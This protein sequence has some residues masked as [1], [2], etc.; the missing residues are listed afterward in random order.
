M[1]RDAVICATIGFLMFAAFIGYQVFAIGA[2]PLTL[3]VGLV[4]LMC[5][6]DFVSTIRED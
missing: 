4:L 5:L 1:N 2:L 3:I 6:Y